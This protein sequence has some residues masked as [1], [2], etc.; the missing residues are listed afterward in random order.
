MRDLNECKAEIFSRSEKAIKIREKKRKR[1]LYGVLPALICIGIF[2]AAIFPN[3]PYLKSKDFD[4]ESGDAGV[5]LTVE[6]DEA[7]LCR[8]TDEEKAKEVYSNILTLFNGDETYIGESVA[9]SS[10]GTLGAFPE[11]SGNSQSAEYV[12]TFS[13]D[14]EKELFAFRDGRLYREATG[15]SVCVSEEELKEIINF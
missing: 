7:E 14:G 15:E 13:L 11:A 10:S 8:I 12:L 6:G 2:T 9:G 1:I 3:M 4:A 5:F